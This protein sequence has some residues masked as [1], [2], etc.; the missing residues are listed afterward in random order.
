MNTAALPETKLQITGM[1]CASCVLRV[2]KALAATPGVRSAS[3]N[4]ATEE[5]SVQT[6]A[7]VGANTLTAAVRKALALA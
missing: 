3:V 4:L 2:E 5:A 6:D 1:I 7:A